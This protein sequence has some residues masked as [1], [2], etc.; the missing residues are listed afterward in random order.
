MMTRDEQRY[1]V[2][3]KRGGVVVESKACTGTHMLP[4]A[5]FSLALKHLGVEIAFHKVTP[6]RLVYSAPVD[7]DAKL[8][9]G[10]ES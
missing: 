2:L 1:I 5:M 7:V 3:A 4:V 9:S 6:L 10:G 8:A